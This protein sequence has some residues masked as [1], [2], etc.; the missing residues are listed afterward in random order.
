MPEF[1]MDPMEASKAAFQLMVQQLSGGDLR[2]FFQIVVGEMYIRG[3]TDEAFAEGWQQLSDSV[4][5]MFNPL[6]SPD[7]E[8]LEGYIE[9]RDELNEAKERRFSNAFEAEAASELQALFEQ[10]GVVDE[11]DET[12]GLYL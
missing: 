7:P 11:G 3:D 9:A 10:H 4:L 6:T 1:D 8:T 2:D 5:E 12:P